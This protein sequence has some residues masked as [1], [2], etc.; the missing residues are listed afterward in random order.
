MTRVGI[1]GAG[2]MGSMHANVYSMLPDVKIVGIADIRGEKAKSLAAKFKTIPYYDPH[3]LISKQDVNVI[4]ICLPTFLHKEFVIKAAE[5]SKDI[6]CEKPIALTVED[7][8]EMIEACK[9]NK[10]Q[11]MI[12][13]VI[14]FWHEYRFLK[15]VYDRG[16]YGDLKSL[17][18]KRLSPT[19]TWGWENWLLKNEQ[20][21][22][23]LID[24][25][26]HDTDF[27]LYLTGKTPR[28]V[29]SKV[30]KDESFYSHI[31]TTFTFEN[32]L[33]VSLEGGWNFP[34]QF[35]FEMSYIANFEKAV[36]SFNSRNNP[37][38]VVYE[39]SG[40][41]DKPVFEKI[42]TEGANGNID[43][44]GGYYYEIRY[45]IEHISHNKH[46]TVITPEE[47]RHSLA[48]LLVEK[49]SIDKN[50]EILI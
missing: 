34:S 26:I 23:A 5:N 9:K 33:V 46:F 19:P 20:S 27:V 2:F 22:G 32:N 10:V 42:K 31:F 6:F 1:I 11:L 29:Y 14:R 3:Q 35:P 45:F 40:K 28:K 18:C 21:G 7:A 38:L 4:D 24:L 15:K 49:E 43:D 12:G 36:V 16:D 25:H 17:V 50:L 39:S 41:V 30:T 37:T 44:L 47:A 13:H 48:V 8:D